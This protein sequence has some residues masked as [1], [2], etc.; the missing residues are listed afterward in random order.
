MKAC[1]LTVQQQQ[2]Q[3]LF[4]QASSVQIYEIKMEHIFICYIRIRIYTS[5]TTISPILFLK[6]I[7]Q[8]ACMFVSCLMA[9]SNKLRNLKVTRKKNVD[10]KLQNKDDMG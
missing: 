5:F 8:L 2:Q 6:N 7:I 3:S 10:H 4:S 1:D 9:E